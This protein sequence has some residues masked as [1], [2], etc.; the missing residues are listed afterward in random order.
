MKKLA[1]LAFAALAAAPFVVIACGGDDSKNPKYPS[2]DGGAA[3]TAT[4]ATTAEES[5]AAVTGVNDNSAGEVSGAAKGAYDDGFKA[6]ASGDLATAKQKFREAT[7]NDPKNSAA[8]YSLGCVLERLGDN[9]GAQNAYR[10][11]FSAK[12]DNEVAMGAYALNLAHTGHQSDA[13]SFLTQKFQSRPKSARL[14]SYLAEVKS[15]EK[16]SADAQRMA[17]DALR[18]DPND[19]EAMVV[20]ARD[21]Y[22]AGRTDL[23]KYALTAILDGFGQASPARDPGNA[24]ALLLRGLIEREDGRRIAAMKDFDAARLKRPDLVEATIQVA[25]MKL[26]AG[27]ATEAQPLLESAVKY[28]PENAI[29]HMNLGDCYRLQQRYADAKRELDR[30]LSLDSTLLGAHYALGLMY[31]N[32]PSYP[33]MDQKAQVAAAIRELEQYKSMRGPHAP[34]GTSD[35]IDDLVARAHDKQ[36][37]MNMPAVAPAPAATKKP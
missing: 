9:T 11:A 17:Q 21:H 34:P 1:F 19:K 25:A 2:K 16:D 31:L 36:N 37:Q 24:E 32:A 28:A 8:Y 7:T 12:S 22:R 6:W 33:G 20:I 27:N 5:D 10:Q 14:E 23:A 26:E 4:E 13:D 3:S 35:D 29:A 30:A 15:L 18:L